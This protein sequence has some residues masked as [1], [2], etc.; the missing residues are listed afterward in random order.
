MGPREVEVDG[1]RYAARRGIVISAGGAPAIPP[2]AGLK[3]IDHWT[4]RDAT[5]AKEAPDSLVVL[6]G[7][8]IG[9]EIGQAFRRFG[10]AVT[11]VEMAPHILPLESQRMP[12]RSKRFCA[13]TASIY[14]PA[15]RPA[16]SDDLPTGSPSS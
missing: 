12:K 15:F 8:P 1:E 3:E 10:T 6:G 16:V 7:G 9:L 13:P 14:A 5:E 2:I 11:V 4:N